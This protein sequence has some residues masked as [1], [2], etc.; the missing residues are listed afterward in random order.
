MWLA[1]LKSALHLLYRGWAKV[2]PS[3]VIAEAGCTAAGADELFVAVGEFVVVVFL[4]EQA[5]ATI[6]V[7]SATIT[8]NFERLTRLLLLLWGLHDPL[9]GLRLWRA[10]APLDRHV[11]APSG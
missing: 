5:T 3:P 8:N 10:S 4:L 7:I 11:S 2:L 6:P 9:H 1:A